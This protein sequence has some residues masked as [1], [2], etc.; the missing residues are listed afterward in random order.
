MNAPRRLKRGAFLVPSLLTTAN[1]ALGF[2]A[3]VQAV[4]GFT[5]GLGG[6]VFFDRSAIAIGWAIIFDGWDGRVARLMN[7]TSDFGRELDS[8]A[9]C[10][11]FGLAPAFLAYA[12]G[13]AAVDPYTVGPFHEH[14]HRAGLVICFLF[15]V[16]GAA[17]LARFNI[18]TNP[19]PTNPGKPGRK[20]FV[21]LA[22][23]AGAG[24]IAA[25]VHFEN[26]QVNDWVGWPVMWMAI[27]LGTSLLMVSTWRYYS[28]KDIHLGRANIVL[29]AAVLGLVYLFSEQVLLLVALLY[30]GSGVV[31]RIAHMFRRKP[32][33][34]PELTPVE[35][36]Q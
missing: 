6:A 20:Y 36:A 33:P 27:V 34:R 23:P 7:A 8:L 13:I 2:Y 12:W 21:G 29:I 19:I 25:I 26:G 14:L 32:Q 18:S 11:T 10:I 3:L 16:C 30:T 17:R 9:D 31:F 35:G 28:F 22:I 24:V 15:L 4:L 1:M 5:K